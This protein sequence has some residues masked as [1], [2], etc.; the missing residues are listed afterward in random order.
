MSHLDAIDEIDLANLERVRDLYARADPVPAG[1]LER[2][3]FAIT[4]QALHAEVAELMDSALLATRGPGTGTEATRVESVTFSAPAVSL[5]VSVS[6][7][8]GHADRVR[9]DGY[10]TTPG[11]WVEAVVTTG[12][13]SVE[14]DANGRFV[15]DDLPH[16]PIHFVIRVDPSDETVRP[17][18]TPTMEV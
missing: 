4:V 10:V 11:A 7:A 18:I 14:T 17:V 15:I 16:G 9:I 2:L 12:S 1:L 13:I 8:G 6:P 3:K 5:M